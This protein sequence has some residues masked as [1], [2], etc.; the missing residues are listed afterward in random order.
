M[1]PTHYNRDMRTCIMLSGLALRWS[2]LSRISRIFT[3]YT[4][5]LEIYKINEARE[6]TSEK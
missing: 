4:P 6:Q 2:S 5:I 1:L 3:I